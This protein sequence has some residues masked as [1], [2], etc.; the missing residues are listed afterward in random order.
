MTDALEA[1]YR[2][3]QRLTRRTARNFYYSFLVL[4]REKRRAMCALYAFLRHTDD[5]SDGPGTSDARRTLLADWRYQFDAALVSDGFLVSN[6]GDY[7]GSASLDDRTMATWPDDRNV[8]MDT[9]FSAI[10]GEATG[11]RP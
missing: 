1:S 6:G 3:C 5:L 9:F 7:I 11:H 8:F 2:Q 4:P 10:I